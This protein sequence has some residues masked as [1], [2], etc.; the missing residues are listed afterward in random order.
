MYRKNLKI[1]KNTIKSEI[2]KKLFGMK[3]KLN[4]FLGFHETFK[5]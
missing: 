4:V 1:R 3:L 5:P 2:L